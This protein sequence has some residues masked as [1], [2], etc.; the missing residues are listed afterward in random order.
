MTESY[1]HIPVVGVREG[2]DNRDE[3]YRHTLTLL[4][5][6]PDMIDLYNVGGSSD[7][8][9]RAL[10][11]RG[12]DQDVLFIGHG[13][14]A[15]TRTLFVE[16]TM[17]VVITQSPQFIARKTLHVFTTCATETRRWPASRRSSWKS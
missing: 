1:P 12:R 13:L 2:Y 6:Q 17:D 3:N 11:E 15:D 8:I 10:R 14:T 16:D 9:V 7:G 5:E 4:A